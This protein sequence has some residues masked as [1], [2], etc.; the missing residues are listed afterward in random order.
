MTLNTEIFYTLIGGGPA[1][2]LLSP[3][4]EL[5]VEFGTPLNYAVA[6]RG[7]L[8][9]D[10]TEV[11]LTQIPVTKIRCEMKGG[12]SWQVTVARQDGQELR[13]VLLNNLESFDRA[14]GQDKE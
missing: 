1:R 5:R 11:A 6:P 2:F 4:G 10:D 7:T 14:F 9:L 12:A 13:Q 8:H 3:L